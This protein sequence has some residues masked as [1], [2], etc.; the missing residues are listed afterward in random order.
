MYTCP[1]NLPITKKQPITDQFTLN[2]FQQPDVPIMEQANQ[3]YSEAVFY[4]GAEKLKPILDAFKAVKA[5]LDRATGDHEASVKEISDWAKTPKGE[6]KGPAPKRRPF[7]PKAFW[8]HKVWKDLEDAVSKTFGVRVCEIQPYIEKYN[9]KDKEF[10]TKEL[11]AYVYP[12]NRFPIEALISEQGFY[13]KSHSLVI[14][15]HISL[16]LIKALDPEEILAVMLHEMGHGIDPALVD[17][18]Y[19]ETNVLSKYI[20]DRKGAIN[21]NEQ[22]AMKQNKLTEA[23]IIILTYIAIIGIMFIPGIINFFRRLFMGKKK[24]EEHEQQKKL[25]RIQDAL[26]SDRRQFNRQTYSEAFADN[27]ARMYGYGGKLMSGLQKINRAYDDKMKSWYKKESIRQEMIT[28]TTISV[29]SDVH[30]TD[31]HRIR[32]LLREYEQDLKDPNI[33]EEV[34]KHMREDKEEL[35]KVLDQYLNHYD[36][37]QNRVNRMIDEELQKIDKT[38]AKK[39]EKEDEKKKAAVLPEEEPV[40]ESGDIQFHDT[41]GIIMITESKKAYEK[42]RAADEALTP[43]DRK[44]IKK[45]F[46]ETQCSFGKDKEGY[47]CFT[48]R[49]RSKYYETIDKIPKKDVDFVSSTS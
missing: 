17:I 42:L 43:E 10:E 41:N 40:K 4:G 15:M 22:K 37:F 3:F 44:E 11:N 30:K 45:R 18:K 19:L 24:Y 46:G 34:K 36:E 25:K 49:A 12:T 35:E 47:Y 39:A 9:S 16:G 48:H 6:A 5:E 38:S 33:P 20:T 7:D 8:K 29:L 1:L 2:I 13:D 28:R 14:K 27:F 23:G 26:N 21:K 32:N 31:I